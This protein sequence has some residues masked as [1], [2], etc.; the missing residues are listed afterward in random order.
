MTAKIFIGEQLYGPE[1]RDNPGIGL[2]TTF[3]TMYSSGGASFKALVGPGWQR[4]IQS[5]IDFLKKEGITEVVIQNGGSHPTCGR[6]VGEFNGRIEESL[7]REFEQK[8][9]ESMSSF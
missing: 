2:V 7:F 4:F 9:L 6:K 5:T 1:H 3:G 8:I